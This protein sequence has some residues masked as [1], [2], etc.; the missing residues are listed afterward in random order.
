MPFASTWT[1]SE[2]VILSEMSQ[3]NKYHRIS[4]ICGIVKKKK[5]KL[6]QMTLF[7]KQ[8]H[9]RRKQT[10]CYRA[11]REGGMSREPESDMNTAE[12]K[13]DTDEDPLCSS[14]ACSVLCSDAHGKEIQTS[15]YTNTYD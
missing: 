7:T 9:L 1:D 6:V 4:F 10:Y 14:G 11:K 15:G 8:R 5:K 13:A 3:R 12:Y 2:F